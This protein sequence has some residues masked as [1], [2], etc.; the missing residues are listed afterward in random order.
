MDESVPTTNFSASWTRVD[1]TGDPA[2]YS[3][4]L[5]A[6]RAQLLERARRDPATMFGPLDLK[7]GVRVLDIGCG[8]GDYLRAL[9]PLV[10]PGRAVGIDLST[11]LIT[12]ARQRTG[13]TDSNVAFEEAD[14][15]DLPFQDASFERVLATQVLL[16]LDDP[17]RAVAQMRRVLTPGGRLVL[18][19]WDWDSTCLAASDRDFGRRF[20]H[21]LCDQ[22]RN[23]LIVRELSSRLTDERF[24][25][26]KVIP[27]VQ[28]AHELDPVFEWL[29]EPATRALVRTGQLTAEDGERFLED[30]RDRAR[31]GRYFLARTYYT[32]TAIAN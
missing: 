4:L 24:G 2:F 1:Q 22:M 25:H 18:G 10:S 7:P 5:D 3:H 21:L 9:A 13:R 12:E 32:V 31:A 26:V 29:I 8:T 17:W 6:T 15:Y 19:E 28:I 30:L 20:T 14:A 16:H 23:G 11:T 27:D